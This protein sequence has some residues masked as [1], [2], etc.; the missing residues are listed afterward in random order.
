VLRIVNTNWN[1]KWTDLIKSLIGTSKTTWKWR[2]LLPMCRYARPFWHHF[3]VLDIRG[4][5]L[6]ISNIWVT[7]PGV[8]QPASV[9]LWSGKASLMSVSRGLDN[10]PCQ[11]REETIGCCCLPPTFKELLTHSWVRMACYSL[12]PHLS[13]RLS[14]KG[15]PSDSV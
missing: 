12:Y 11:T 4:L 5:D 8:F 9:A 1:R 3:H 6:N 14:G 2:V 7:K 10:S 13:Y 15:V